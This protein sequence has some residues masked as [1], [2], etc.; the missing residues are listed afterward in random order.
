MKTIKNF[1]WNNAGAIFC[2]SVAAILFLTIVAMDLLGIIKIT[3]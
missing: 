3:M 1:L 2:Y